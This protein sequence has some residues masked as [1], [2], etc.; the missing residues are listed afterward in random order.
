MT[1][2]PLA[3]VLLMTPAEIAGWRAHFRR[4]PPDEEA[5]LLSLMVAMWASGDTPTDKQ[6][7]P[8]RYPQEEI[9]EMIEEQESAKEETANR[10]AMDVMLR[11]GR[12]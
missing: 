4:N 12:R 5:R 3:S 8:W 11:A 7:R 10:N 6:L 9:R 2:T 1:A